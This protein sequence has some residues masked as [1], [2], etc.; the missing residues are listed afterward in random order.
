MSRRNRL[1]A[2]N[3]ALI[4]ALSAMND[5][6][7]QELAGR[8]QR[9][10][11]HRIRR[12]ENP[13]VTVVD[14]LRAGPQFKCKTVACWCCRTAHVKRKK[15]LAAA[16]FADVANAHCSFVTVN[17]AMP[18]D[19]L[20]GVAA[21]HTKMVNDLD[22]LRDGLS[23][24]DRRYARMSIFAILEVGHDGI[25]WHPHWHLLLA[26]PRIDRQE[27]AA[28]FR[29]RFP[30]ARRV[31][32]Q[33]FHSD[34][35]V[36]ENVANCVGYAFK[37]DHRKWSQYASSRLFL[38]IRQRAALRSMCSLLRAKVKTYSPL[39]ALSRSDSKSPISPLV[40]PMPVVV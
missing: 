28:V 29:Q 7:A 10:R 16:V 12:R 21:A 26:H 19:D 6:T 14:A 5:K 38:W 30:G 24:R 1:E 31:Q 25:Q 20:D 2:E 34:N 8:M 18:C 23:R 4:A 3:A 39:D 22:N 13:A 27:V 40:E 32:V 17:A 9:C 33:S 36:R 35:S 11:E 37:F 15:A